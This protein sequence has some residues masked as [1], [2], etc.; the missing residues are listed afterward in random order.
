MQI[1][2]LLQK[3]YNGAMWELPPTA[4]LNQYPSKEAIVKPNRKIYL[5][6]N[7]VTLPT[8]RVPNIIDGSLK[9]AQLLFKSFDLKVENIE[10]VNDIAINAIQQ[11][12]VE[13]KEVTRDMLKAGFMVPKGTAISLKV[14][15]GL[16]RAI[17]DVPDLLGRPIDEVEELLIGLGL[18]LG[19]TTFVSD[20]SIKVGH[21]KKQYPESGS[22]RRLR[23]GNKVDIWVVDREGPSALEEGE[24]EN[25]ATSVD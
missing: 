25:D 4:I 22:G 10:Y 3:Y 16:G 23:V 5:T 13:G 17:I 11:I 21:I 14:G 20:P 2:A 15:N 18:K 7:R 12:F 8:T 1:F 19:K 9:N 24:I 6:I